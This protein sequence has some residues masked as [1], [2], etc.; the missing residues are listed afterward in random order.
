MSMPRTRARGPLLTPRGLRHAFSRLA[1]AAFLGVMPAALLVLAIVGAAR[2]D[3]LAVD[4]HHELY[5]QAQLMLD[6]KNPFPSPDADITDTTNNVWPVS[7]VILVLPF[8]V[9]PSELADWAMTAA[10]V[11][12]LVSALLVAGV[13]D[14][15]VFGAVC[16]WPPVVNAVQTANLTLPLCLLAALAWRTRERRFAP[17]AAVGVAVAVKFFLWP[18]TPWLLVRR[19][20]A[21]A[22]VAVAIVSGSLLLITPFIGLAD[23]A[24]VLGNLSDTFDGLGYTL[25]ALLTDLGVQEHVAKAA[26]LVLGLTALA[27]ARRRSFALA[28]GA[29]LLLSPIV[30]LHF[31]ALLAVPLA[32][33]RPRFTPVWLAPLLLWL[34]PGTGNGQTW[35]TALTLVVLLGLLAY[36]VRAEA[37]GETGD[38][39]RTLNRAASRQAVAASRP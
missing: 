11:A 31:L 18:L 16:Y 14:W 36:C 20:V 32:V 19:R 27:V 30:W 37:A 4:F 38:S 39:P 1:P 23:Y 34:V 35:Q 21:A 3:Q 2:R 7:A 6:G 24:R 28:L 5:P 8:A 29:S 12:T 26:W 9:L 33:V 17:G 10:V 15:R 22:V 25:Y 13:R